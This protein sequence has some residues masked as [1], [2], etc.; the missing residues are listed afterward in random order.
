MSFD[1]TIIFR[2]SH[3]V[4]VDGETLTIGL[5]EDA[6]AEF[7]DIEG[8]EFPEDGDNVSP[9]EACGSLEASGHRVNLYS[10]VNGEITEINK[11][12]KKDLS[13]IEEDPIGE[14]WLFKVE[15]SDPD[16]VSQL[17]SGDAPAYDD[18][19]EEDLEEDDMDGFFE[20]ENF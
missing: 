12:L 6:M 11:S 16:E 13:I 3:W 14:G 7:D 19:D 1:D 9:D 10:P 20:E 15:A 4:T 17:L 5:T 2:N 8:I 18:E